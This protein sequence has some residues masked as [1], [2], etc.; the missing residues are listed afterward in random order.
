[1]HISANF[2]YLEKFLLVEEHYVF[3]CI[4]GMVCSAGLFMCSAKR[5]SC[6]AQ[7]TARELGF[8]V[9]NYLSVLNCGRGQC[10]HICGTWEEV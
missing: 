9:S 1:M 5:T 4:H 3:T 6:L 8:C 10:V 7:Q 2:M